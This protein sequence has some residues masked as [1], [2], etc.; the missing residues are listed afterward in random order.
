M[1]SEIRTLIQI[2]D[3][4]GIELECPDCKAKVFYPV[5]KNYERIGNL[6]PNCNSNW[7]ILEDGPYNRGSVSIEQIKTLLKVFK[8]L[9]K[10]G[11]DMKAILHL[12][13]GVPSKD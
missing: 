1:T 3:I 5:E 12:H 7:F 4:P 13:V 10:P 6:C 11:A 8:L 2:S 9:G